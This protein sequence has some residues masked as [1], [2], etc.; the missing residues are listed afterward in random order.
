[1][2][3]RRRQKSLDFFLNLARSWHVIFQGNTCLIEP[4]IACGLLVQFDCPPELHFAS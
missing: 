2:I 1:M 4:I 3:D